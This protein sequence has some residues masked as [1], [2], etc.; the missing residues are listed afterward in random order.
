ML[1]TFPAVAKIAV[2]SG[3]EVLH[4]LAAVVA[5]HVIVEVL[6][7][8]LNPIVIRAIG[9]QKVETHLASPCCQRQLNLSA[10]V[11]FE[12]V[13][14]NVNPSS[15]SIADGHQPIDEKKEQ[16]AVLAF[17]LNPREFARAGVQRPTR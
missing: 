16:N 3:H 1:S 8:P 2:D 11:D 17:S 4:V 5:S 12:V 10:V 9:W 15:V 6:P 7:D 13:D 14:D